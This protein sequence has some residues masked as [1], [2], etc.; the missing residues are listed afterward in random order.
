MGKKRTVNK[1]GGS[2]NAGMRARSLSR[3]PKKKVVEGTL[4]IR[5]TYNNTQATFTD[6]SGNA[7]M[8]GSSG[9]LGFKGAKKSTP[10]AAAKVGEVLGEK[11]ISIGVKEVNVVIK[12]VGAGRESAMRA[13][14]GKGVTLTGIRDETPVPHNGPRAPKPRRV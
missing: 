6:K 13:F 4:Y 1:A 7:I 12:G 11:A 8:S 14:A 5:A 2:G 3:V 10:F 9:S